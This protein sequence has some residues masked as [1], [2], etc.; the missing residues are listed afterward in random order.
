MKIPQLLKLVKST[1]H[2]P[3]NDVKYSDL[4]QP[5]D[6]CHGIYFMVAPDES[7]YYI[8][9]ASKRCLADR[10]GAH[11][12]SRKDSYMNSFLK[13]ILAKQEVKASDKKLNECYQQAKNW[14][15]GVL[16]VK[17]EECEQL[18]KLIELAERILIYYLLKEQRCLNGCNRKRP[19]DTT[20]SLFET[21]KQKQLYKLVNL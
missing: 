8:G 14:H 3:L 15:F 16:F 17:G 4:Y 11:F 10:M 12:D 6:S 20:I 1:P 9:K 7:V 2:T 13:A 19:Y 21:L 18:Y 5:V